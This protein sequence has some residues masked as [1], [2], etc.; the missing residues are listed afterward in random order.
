MRKNAKRYA[1]P[2]MA[3]AMAVAFACGVSAE[4]K[5]LEKVTFCLDWMWKLYSR[6]KMVQR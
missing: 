6:Q 5:D 3:M 2:A 4:D 1:V